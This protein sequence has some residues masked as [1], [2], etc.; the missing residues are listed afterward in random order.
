MNKASAQDRDRQAAGRQIPGRLR[1]VVF[2]VAIAAAAPAI[3]AAPALAAVPAGNLLVNPEAEAPPSLEASGVYSA[4]QGWTVTAALEGGEALEEGVQGPYDYC[5]RGG[6]D[7]RDFTLSSAGEAIGGGARFFYGG[8]TELATLQQEISAPLEAAGR[9]LLIGG[10]FGGYEDQEDHATLSAQFLDGIGAE[11]GSAVTTPPVTA[12]ERGETTSLLSRQASGTV[13]AGTATIRFVL[14]QVREE[15]IDNDGYAD[16]L[17]ATFDGAPP[18]RPAPSGDAACPLAAAPVTTPPVAQPPAPAPAPAPAPVLEITK[19]PAH[20]TA[21]TAAVFMFAGTP[22]GSYECSLDGGAWKACSSGHDF[23]P[24]RPG[25]HLFEV[26]EKLNGATSAIAA[27]RWTV[28]LPKACVLRVA[29][30]RVFAYAKHD[31]ARLVIR[32]TTY[33]PASVT[34]TYALKG[35]K[36]KLKLGSATRRF[37]KAGV[38]RLPER[39]TAAQIGK[40]RAA[41]AFRVHF[42]I[43]KTPKSCGRYYTKRLTIPRKISGQTVWFQS[44]STFAAA[45]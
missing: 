38:F 28:D 44:D 18:A 4:P 9:T 2:I 35:S 45:R 22:G 36:G 24:A 29:R 42:R 14:S 23:G 34:V 26:R 3:A 12:A 39:L 27:Y 15:G 19:G 30:A 7:G 5:Y 43:A 8:E 13:P 21:Q 10:D 1:L 6:D 25:D 16:N 37:H 11:L 41:K 17:Y 31:K 32:Y 40:V 20:E 33:R